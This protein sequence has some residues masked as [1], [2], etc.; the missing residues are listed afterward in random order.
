MS[1]DGRLPDIERR[2]CGRDA[3]RIHHGK[4]DADQPQVQIRR[5]SQ[6]GRYIDCDRC[7]I[8]RFRILRTETIGKNAYHLNTIASLSRDVMI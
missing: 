2:L 4:E 3:A 1:A 7:L 8:R 6:H 5:L